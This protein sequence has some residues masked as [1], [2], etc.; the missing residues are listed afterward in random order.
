MAATA[1]ISHWAGAVEG[2]ILDPLLHLLDAAAA[3]IAADI[4][5][6]IEHLAQIQ[7]LV[8]AEVIG[9]GNAAPMRV[10]HGRALRSW[11]DAVHPMIFIREATTRPAQVRNLH[12]SQRR[13]YIVTNAARVGY[14]RILAHPDATVDAATQVFGEVPIDVP[15]D[16]GFPKIGI[17][18]NLVHKVAV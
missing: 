15:A 3:D 1:Q 2:E 13:D 12:R 11:A 8:G 10:D 18:D 14:R 5:L 9:L 17:D 6:T 4:R 7:K 16:L